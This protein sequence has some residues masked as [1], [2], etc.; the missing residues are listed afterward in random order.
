MLFDPSDYLALPGCLE[1]EEVHLGD[2]RKAKMDIAAIKMNGPILKE[3]FS[4]L[5]A[6][7]SWADFLPFVDGNELL[8]RLTVLV[9]SKCGAWDL[10]PSYGNLTYEYPQIRKISLVPKPSRGDL[11]A[12]N[13]PQK[14]AGLEGKEPD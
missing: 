12:K 7:R 14:E 5:P 6:Y 13:P 8:A 4:S 9:G 11:E 2:G 1:E 3:Y 10:D